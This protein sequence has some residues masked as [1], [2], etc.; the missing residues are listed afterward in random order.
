[1]KIPV[2]VSRWSSNVWTITIVLSFALSDGQPK[3]SSSC[4]HSSRVEQSDPLVNTQLR[5]HSTFTI[6]IM[7]TFLN[8]ITTN[9][10]RKFYN[11]S[12]LAFFGC[13]NLFHCYGYFALK[14]GLHLNVNVACKNE[15][16]VWYRRVTEVRQTAFGCVTNVWQTVEHYPSTVGTSKGICIQYIYVKS[17]LCLGECRTVCRCTIHSA[18]HRFRMCRLHSDV[19]PALCVHYMHS[20]L[21]IL[22]TNLSFP[23]ALGGFQFLC[24]CCPMFKN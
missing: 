1:M 14:V 10:V 12:R 6:H 19:N 16:I 9:S 7:H 8:L 24:Q 4:F 11:S 2:I 22:Y 21:E 17:I 15:A 23:G 13:S 18:S 5:H 3:H 20:T